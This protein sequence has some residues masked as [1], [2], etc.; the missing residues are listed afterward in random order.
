M[1]ST[2]VAQGGAG[3]DLTR[4]WG[5]SVVV[6]ALCGVESLALASMMRWDAPHHATSNGTRPDRGPDQGVA[7]GVENQND[8][9]DVCPVGHET[10]RALIDS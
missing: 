7:S 4:D 3:H 2:L 9:G 6:E 8:S 10:C 5:L 1:T